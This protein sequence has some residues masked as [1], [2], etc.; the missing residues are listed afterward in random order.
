MKET[1]YN[2]IDI[3]EVIEQEMLALWITDEIPFLLKKDEDFV[4][5]ITSAIMLE[6]PY[7]SKYMT[8]WEARQTDIPGGIKS[9]IAKV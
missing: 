1:K 5:I 4:H 2:D 6:R 9:L 7:W 8:V 3:L